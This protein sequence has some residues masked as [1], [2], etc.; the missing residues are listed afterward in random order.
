MREVRA[1]FDR[2]SGEF[3]DYY[4][5]RRRNPI[6]ALGHRFLREPGMRKRFE[7]TVNLAGD[8]SGRRVLDVGCGT[9]IYS[10][11]FAQRGA[12]VSAIDIS[13][14]MYNLALSNA[15]ASSVLGKIDF[16]LGDFLSQK[17]DGPFDYILAI[18]VFDYVPR[19][20]RD[21]LMFKFRSLS[22]GRTI[23][24]FPRRFIFQA[25]IR[26]AMFLWRRMSVYFYTGREIVE[27]C[28]RN[29]FEKIKFLNSGPIWTVALDV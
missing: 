4:K 29:G 14:N 12:A 8:V 18:G 22:R 3:D 27:L 11:Y 13:K 25:P 10:I 7:D 21:A 6:G 23:V 26:K 5:G 19:E 15:K 1:Y 17:I 28:R 20:G 2:M 24:T 16:I 9:G